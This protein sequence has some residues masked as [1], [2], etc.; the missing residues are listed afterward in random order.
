VSDEQ[1]I[2]LLRGAS[3]ATRGGVQRLFDAIRRSVGLN[4][5]TLLSL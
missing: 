1:N 5:T 4:S 3:H 2:M